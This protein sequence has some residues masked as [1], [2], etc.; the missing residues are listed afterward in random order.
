MKRVLLWLV[1]VVLGVWVLGV[2]GF[3]ALI[4]IGLVGLGFYLYK[5]NEKVL[6]VFNK[7]KKREVEEIVRVVHSPVMANPFDTVSEGVLV[8]GVVGDVPVELGSVN[9]FDTVSERVPVEAVVTGDGFSGVWGDA[10]WVFQ[11]GVLTVVGGEDSV[12]T[13]GGAF[14]QPWASGGVSNEEIVEI[15]FVNP[16]GIAFPSN[17][18]N[19]F[20]G[21]SGRDSLYNLEKI[22]GI[23]SVRVGQVVNMDHLF[24]G[25]D[26]L[27]EL[28]LSAWDV[29]NVES[30][31]G[32][33]SGVGSL[34]RVHYERKS[35]YWDT[36]I[37]LNV[38]GWD[39]GKVKDMSSLF[40]RSGLESISVS[41]WDTGS[42]EKMGGMFQGCEKLVEIVGIED[43]VTSSVVDMSSMFY[44]VSSLVS[45]D[46]S[47]WDTGRV[48]N[49][50]SMFKDSLLLTSVIVAGWNVGS[51]KTMREMFYSV[52]NLSFESD[53]VIISS[54]LAPMEVS[55]RV[56][57]EVVLDLTGWNTTNLENM[58]DMFYGSGFTSIEG[59][60]GLDTSKVE[61]M[62]GL[63]SNSSL[64]TISL[65]DWDISNVRFLGSMFSYCDSLVEVSVPGWLLGEEV[66]TDSMF[67][68][69]GELRWID[70]S[71]WVLK[72]VS[73]TG[74]RWLMFHGVDK[75]E[76]IVVG[77][78]TDLSGATY[79]NPSSDSSRDQS[80]PR[81]GRIELEGGGVG[82]NSFKEF[83]EG[84]G[85][86]GFQ[87][88]VYRV[89]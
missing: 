40:S 42:V 51:V 50:S 36:K 49:M 62:G 55:V 72:P 84:T 32:V 76:T 59:L 58:R 80:I 18:K 64:T 70:L 31:S 71:G 21:V 9:P 41:G 60:E 66:F 29:S 56:D 44:G 75:L 30:M 23:E 79:V 81:L 86:V 83:L 77:S 10:E 68:N 87:G 19:L 53:D 74:G 89:V 1:G 37:F 13:L 48:E 16:E 11:E 88:G 78:E 35:E 33:F 4:L 17:S 43:W 2:F 8:E 45:L 63:F 52:G 69:C 82:F 7:F 39:T 24:D 25:A 20:R 22:F 26:S 14:T 57:R 34:S 3:K 46:L 5:N 6:T 38:S 65:F 12:K 61:D 47:G 54:E 85:E 73:E 67:L 27:V 28:D 15:R